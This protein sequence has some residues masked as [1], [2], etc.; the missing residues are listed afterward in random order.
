M[1]NLEQTLRGALQTYMGYPCNTAYDFSAVEKFINIH[2]NNVGDPNH[3]GIYRA[4]SKNIELEVLQFFT[5]LWN[6]NYENSWGYITNAG[7]EG[8]LQGL[9]VA[10]ESAKGQP[11]IFY[12][13]ENSHYSIFKIARILQLNMVIIKSQENGEMDYNDFD[14]KL[15]ENTNKYVIV[16]ANLG[17]TMKGAIDNTREIYRIIKKHH[18][19]ERYYIHADGALTGFYLPFIEKDLFFK[20]H[21]SSL[22]ISCHKFTGVPF[23]CGVFIMESRFLKL[24]AENIEYI[25]SMDC[26]I[27]GSRNG[28]APIFLKHIIDTK[29]YE[30]FKTDI[31]KCIELAEYAVEKIP[32]SWRNHNSITVVIPKPSRNEI[33][34]KWQLAT[35]GDIS[36]LVI[37]PHVT[38]EKIDLF[39]AEII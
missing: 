27:T 4:N 11:H 25:G 6:I 20:A 22:S 21:I 32:N 37:M 2:I 8:N 29:G 16:C 35:Q 13:T 5:K 10:R 36:H 19:H 15:E 38:R 24:V 23:P 28:H 18:F 31:E 7:T 17:T 34:Q 3:S 12:T 39:A 9:Y 1:E 26:M 14:K 33:I 30:G